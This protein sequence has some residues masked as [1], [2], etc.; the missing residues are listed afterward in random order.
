NNDEKLCNTVK[1]IYDNAKNRPFEKEYYRTLIAPYSVPFSDEHIWFKEAFK[2]AKE[3]LNDAPLL[4]ENLADEASAMPNSTEKY[5]AFAETVSLLF[6]EILRCCERENWD[7]FWN[8]LNSAD[9]PRMPSGKNNDTTYFKSINEKLKRKISDLK[10]LFYT[11]FLSVKDATENYEKPL[12]L[13]TQITQKYSDKMLEIKRE[14]NYFTFADI[15][16]FALNVMCEI[17]DGKINLTDTALSLISKYEE[18]FVDEFQDVNDL[19]NTLFDILSNNMKNLFVVGDIKQSIYGFRGSNPD[20]FLRKKEMFIPCDTAKESE[21]KKVY[22]SDNFRSR[23]EICDYVN[24]VFSNILSGQVGNLVYDSDE[25][26]NGKSKFADTPFCKTELIIADSAD[27]DESNSAIRFEAKA[28]AKSI[29]EMMASG[30]TV[31]D[32]EGERKASYKDIVILLSTLTDKAPVIADELNKSGIPVNYSS[33]NFFETVEIKVFTSLLKII[34]NPVN[35]VELLTVMMSPIFSFSAEEMANMR[36]NTRKGRLFSCVINAAENGNEKAQN[37]LNTLKEY[38]MRSTMLS[39][40][41]TVSYLFNTTN[42]LD[43]VSAMPGGR[44]R[45]AN[46]LALQNI[47]KSF[48]S[49]GKDGILPFLNY[50]SSLPEKSIKT[51]VSSGDGVRIM[52]MHKSKG[53]QFPICIVA[54][55]SSPLNRSDDI[56]NVILSDKYGIGIRHGDYEEHKTVDHICHSLCAKE[57]RMS[58]IA[59]R[60]RLLYV[61]MTRAIDKLVL[62]CRVNE[63]E[64]A[65]NKAA[66]SLNADF[67]YISAS[68]VRNTYAMSDWIIATALIHPSGEKLRALCEKR[69]CV[70]DT[71]CDLEIKIINTHNTVLNTDGSE[72]EFTPDTSLS[73]KTSENIKYVYPYKDLFAIKAKSSV[74]DIANKAESERFNFTLLPYFMLENGLT[75]AGRGSA[76]HKVMQYLTLEK[77]VDVESEIERLFEWQY[78]TESEAKAVDRNAVIAF[79]KSDLFKRITES[80]EVHR[81]LRFLTEVKAGNLEGGIDANCKDE[82]VM[83]QGAVDLCFEENGN[84]IL[85]DF[86]TDRVENGQDLINAYQ[87]QLSIYESACEKIFSKKVSEKIIYSFCLNKEIKL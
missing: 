17:S 57:A 59:E 50:I 2:T 53:L 63:I 71:N 20:N 29:S 31:S 25:Y 70:A 55:L 66:D 16:Q 80:K 21:P 65:L 9:I 19:Q 82:P 37:F 60:M 77:D 84:I 15:E 86:K 12:K 38:R 13:L 4:I 26:L 72:A 81:E 48:V 74:S 75:P 78:I 64:K 47:A 11:D 67:P 3:T 23:K 41:R 83:I 30:Q 5:V 39:L 62:V 73:Q 22:L 79:V 61:A 24:F 35:D 6:D 58:D 1:K 56:S 49:M 69:I 14:Q 34:D 27:D 52:S 46:L 28:I 18:V 44:V 87:K 32:K 33:E 42:Y 51:S 36:I 40:D 54:N 76:V 7:D 85:V 8:A 43:C 68:S 45:R 10:E